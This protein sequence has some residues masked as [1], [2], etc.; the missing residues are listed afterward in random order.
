MQ[1]RTLKRLALSS[2]ILTMA[3]I[4]RSMKI[5]KY[6]L[7]DKEYYNRINLKIMKWTSKKINKSNSIYKKKTQVKVRR[8]YKKTSTN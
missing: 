5:N 8:K 7:I 4:L 3:R 6:K 1:R 2:K